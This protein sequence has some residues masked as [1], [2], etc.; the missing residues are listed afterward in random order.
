MRIVVD[1]NVFINTIGRASP[2]RWLFDDILSG[3]FELC[4]SNDIFFEYWEI[5][6]Q[7]TTTDVAQ[8]VANFLVT[9]LAIV[10]CSP[11]IN[12]NLISADENDYKF[13]DCAVC[14]GAECIITNDGHF[15]VLKSIPFP[16]I[17][18][19]TPEEFKA[20]YFKR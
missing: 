16:S 19:L 4:I 17:M 10:L 2:H 1:T 15:N 6:D 14:V 11:F 3:R 20:Q 9:L 7:Q 12:W 13:V 5:L 8:N 18:V